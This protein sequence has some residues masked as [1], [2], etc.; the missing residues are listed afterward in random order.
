[1]LLGPESRLSEQTRAATD[2]AG[3]FVMDR[4]GSDAMGD[5]DALPARPLRA[6]FAEKEGSGEEPMS[7]A[8]LDAHG[9]LS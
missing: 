7:F 8:A 4:S 6:L 5:N 2:I 9:L 1:M 3:V